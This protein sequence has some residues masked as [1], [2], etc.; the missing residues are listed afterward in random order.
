MEDCERIQ[1]LTELARSGDRTAF[2]KLVEGHRG[3]LEKLVHDRLRVHSVAATEAEDVMQEV[4]I[5]A[6]RSIKGFHWRGQTG[7]LGAERRRVVLSHAGR[8]VNEA[9][10]K[11]GVRVC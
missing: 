5:R 10:G 4:L 2:E 1:D 3:R 6:L 7:T 9:P 8:T 11:V